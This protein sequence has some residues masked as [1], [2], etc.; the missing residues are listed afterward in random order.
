MARLRGGRG[1]ASVSDMYEAAVANAAVYVHMVRD[2]TWMLCTA[3]KEEWPSLFFI[4][5]NRSEMCFGVIFTF[6]LE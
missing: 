1:I 6:L 4:H 3:K 5:S 2:L